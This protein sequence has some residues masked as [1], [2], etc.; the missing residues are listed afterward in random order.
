MPRTFGYD[1]N[2]IVPKEAAAIRKACHAV[3]NGATLWSIA[4]DWNAKGIKTSKGYQW[5]GSKVRQVLLRP[6]IA[7]LAVHNGEILDGV[8]PAWK[9]IIDRDT[10]E[11]VRK[12]LSDP[13]RF[14]GRSMGRKHLLSG[15]A[16]CGECGK[17]MGT[18]SK[19]TKSGTKRLAY[20]CKNIG[21]MK[22]V[23]DLTRTDELV[24]GIITERLADP[25][26]A[27]KADQAHRRHQGA[28][29]ADRHAAQADHRD[30]RRVQRGA[31]RR[32]RPQRPHRPDHREAVPAGGQAAGQPHV[33][34]RERPRREARCRRPVRRAAAGPPSRCDRHTGHGDDS[35][36]GQDGWPVRPGGDHRRL[37]VTGTHSDIVANSG[38]SSE[39]IACR[40]ARR[41][42][43]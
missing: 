34:R 39:P 40:H 2:T 38:L 9:P 3:L 1:G 13:K 17:R 30:P 11:A 6:S 31:D 14:T 16:Y 32:P 22:I 29:R 28:A 20:Q 25:E 35:P 33:T 5:E 18:M 10:W 19:P 21:C 42:D 43:I 41:C 8:T 23:R 27:A 36:A 7:G 26:A 24:I 37:E 12:L 4:K 15:I